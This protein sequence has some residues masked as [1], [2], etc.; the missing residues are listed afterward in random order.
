MT[1]KLRLRQFSAARWEPFEA[2]LI[3][4]QSSHSN[5]ADGCLQQFSFELLVLN[6]HHKSNHA[7]L[8]EAT[9]SHENYLLTENYS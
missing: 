8:I 5:L 4:S 1:N 7:V 3:R 2:N 9:V 6:F